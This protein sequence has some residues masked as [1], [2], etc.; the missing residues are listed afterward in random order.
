MSPDVA[1]HNIYIP[2]SSPCR[3]SM[4]L[5]WF[6]TINNNCE[7]FCKFNSLMAL[8]LPFSAPWLFNSHSFAARAAPG[9]FVTPDLLPRDALCASH[10]SVEFEIPVGPKTSTKHM[11]PIPSGRPHLADGCVP[12]RSRKVAGYLEFHLLHLT[13]IKLFDEVTGVPCRALCR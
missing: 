9:R 10:N 4:S 11:Q 6:V 5:T 8:C 2:R 7:S 3:F 13:A 1:G 12:G